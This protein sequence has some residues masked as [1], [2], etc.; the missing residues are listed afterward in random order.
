MNRILALDM[1]RGYALAAIML[2]HMPVGVLRGGPA[3]GKTDLGVP[4]G[5]LSSGFASIWREMPSW[6]LADGHP[7]RDF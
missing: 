3:A 2:D 6:V 1:L 5:I 7:S 4:R